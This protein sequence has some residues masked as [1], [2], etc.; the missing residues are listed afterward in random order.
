MVRV[1]SQPD[2]HRPTTRIVC[3]RARRRVAGQPRPRDA[4]VARGV[5]L[6]ELLIVVTLLLMLLGIGV[7]LM[8]PALEQGRVREAARQVNA[9]CAVAKARAVQ[10]GR[11][12]GVW[13][14]RSAPGSNA[15]LDLFLAEMPP[16]YTGDFEG[17]TVRFTDQVLPG[18][19]LADQREL[20][21]FEFAETM[22]GM[23]NPQSGAVSS[24]ALIRPGETFF[25]RFNFK[26]S[27]YRV[28]RGPIPNSPVTDP[29]VF[30]LA[31]GLRPTGEFASLAEP[32]IGT[33]FPDLQP[34]VPFQIFRAPVRTSGRALQLTGGAIV[35]LENSGYGLDGRQFAAGSSSDE[36][37]VVIMFQPSGGVERVAYGVNQ[38]SPTGP[39]HLLVGTN[40]GLE[41][42]PNSP[43]SPNTIWY[44]ALDSSTVTYNKNLADSEAVWV[45]VA[46][47]TGNVT[48]AENSWQLLPPP[49]WPGSGPAKPFFQASLRAARE[50]AQTAQTMGGL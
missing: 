9:F 45:S 6:V 31:P 22:H 11:P 20:W 30:V 23:L 18:V 42:S 44:S 43:E 49:P 4:R 29:A 27:I 38:E 48:S 13:M 26:G 2:L 46:H 12:A 14:E 28:R 21:R 37:P 47:R 10:L 25:M 15:C 7:P 16:I 17:A 24:F 19:W 50:F 5:T 3:A 33:S 1:S 39:V 34:G 36:T 8:K 32:P 35:D 41:S 40:A